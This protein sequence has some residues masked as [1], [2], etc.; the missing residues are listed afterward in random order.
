MAAQQA[1]IAFNTGTSLKVIDPLPYRENLAL[2]SVARLVLTDSDGIQE[3]TSVLGTPC[4]PLGPNTER[5]ITVT[6]GTSRLV[7]NDSDRIR[8]AIADAVSGRWGERR[9]IPLWDGAA[10]DRAASALAE[11]CD[12]RGVPART[13]GSL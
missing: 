8:A 1:G 6:H 9:D 7:G 2:M 13:S 12:N 4:L 10:S 3:E 5:P 11:W